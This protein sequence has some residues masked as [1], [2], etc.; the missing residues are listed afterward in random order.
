M[1]IFTFFILWIVSLIVIIGIT[2]ILRNQF[3]KNV[4]FHLF[5]FWIIGNI[6][7]IEGNKFISL[8]DNKREINEIL[9]EKDND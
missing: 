2:F 7:L 9:K 6:V 8:N 3:N 4:F 5:M 1:N